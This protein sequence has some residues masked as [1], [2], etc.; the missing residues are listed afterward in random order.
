[1]SIPLNIYLFKVKNRNNRKWCEINSKLAI[2]TLEQRHWRGAGVFT[3]TF[4]NIL[5]LFLVLLLLI[6]R[7]T[8]KDEDK[9]FED[10]KDEFWG[11]ISKWVLQENKARQIFQKTNVSFPLIRIR[12]CAYQEV[13]YVCFSENLTCFVF[14]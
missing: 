10:E 11:W 8:Q 1:M 6:L 12:T 14:L 7:C 9:S 2:K 5:H 13:K 3:V 4:E